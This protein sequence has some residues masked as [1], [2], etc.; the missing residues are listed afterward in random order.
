MKSIGGHLPFSDNPCCSSICINPRRAIRGILVRI[1]KWTRLSDRAA[2]LRQSQIQ[3]GTEQ[4]Y[5]DLTA[6]KDRFT[7]RRPYSTRMSHSSIFFV[8]VASYMVQ[9]S[10]NQEQKKE[11]QRNHQQLIDMIAKLR[12]DVR[13]LHS[14]PLETSQSRDQLLPVSLA[15]LYCV[16]A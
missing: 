14:V 4:C 15:W 3:I 13:K 5:L 9:N 6:C 12:E 11:Q 8:Q 10:E 1:S 7:V 2:F 16:D